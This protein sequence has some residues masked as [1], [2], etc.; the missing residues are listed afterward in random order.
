MNELVRYRV[1]VLSLKPRRYEVPDDGIFLSEGDVV[2][3]YGFANHQ[4]GKYFDVWFTNPKGLDRENYLTFGKVMRIEDFKKQK[5]MF[6]ATKIGRF[7]V[8]VV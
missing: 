4:I 2:G 3:G 5:G 8:E 1:T 7:L 6:Y